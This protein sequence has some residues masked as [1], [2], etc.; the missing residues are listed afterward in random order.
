MSA[1][2]SWFSQASSSTARFLS[3]SSH[4]LPRWRSPSPTASM[5]PPPI[6]QSTYI[7]PK[8]ASIPTAE[9]A[10]VEKPFDLD[11]R[12]QQL[13][14]DLQFL[15]DAQAEGLI[16]GLE[17]GSL[18]ERSS[19]GSTTPTAQS[20]RS[21]SARRPRKSL[22]RQP[23][24]KSA[25]KGIY[26]SIVALAGLKEEELLGVD[27]KVRD[28]ERILGQIDA[29]EKKREGLREA[30]HNV[31]SSEDTIRSQRLQQ[32]ADALQAEINQV[33]LQLEEMKTRHRK[34]LRQAAAVENSVQAKMASYSN[35]L[36]QLEDDIQRFLNLRP[37]S[38]DPR[39]SSSEGKASIWQLPKK[40][41]NLDL[42][43]EYWTEQRD[44]NVNQR[45][46]VEFEKAALVEG[47]TLWREAVAEINDFEK[48]LRVGM[49]QLPS[50]PGSHSAWEE[51]PETDAAQSL[52]E[53]LA[54]METVIVALQTK[55]QTAE[56][57][58]WRLLMAALG[59]ELDALRRGKQI[60]LGALN[61][62]SGD[63]VTT[64][65]NGDVD[66]NDAPLEKTDSGD[67][68]RA[69]DQSFVTTRPVSH[70][71]DAED[72]EPPPELLFSQARDV[73]TE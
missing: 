70:I 27:A 7:A 73:D 55:L 38:A 65:T 3:N 47:A 30:S 39:P 63:D 25:R 71:S 28:K 57:R 10:V 2:K 69:L 29:W 51:P 46:D 26:N 20:V 68:I 13:E 22:R 12:Q 52:K 36:R 1:S 15:L 5:I 43:R 37:E 45:A 31:D 61:Q 60:L 59:A 32:E 21:S 48:E 4:E 64:T 49:S 62:A 56:E 9:S 34:L 8:S 42:A 14:A 50:S 11:D 19:T 40:R 6:V 53:L 17:A 18:D 66:S 54:K 24:L 58:N 16:R 33:E 72:D 67:E 23:G 35:S 44:S 41:R